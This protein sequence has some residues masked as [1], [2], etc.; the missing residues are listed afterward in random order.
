MK[1]IIIHGILHLCGQDD[2]T[3]LLHE[4]MTKKENEALQM[5]KET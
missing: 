5:W 1:R 3:T 4:E 2:K